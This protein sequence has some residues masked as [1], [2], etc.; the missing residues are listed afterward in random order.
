MLKMMNV[1]AMIQFLPFIVVV[2]LT[3]TLA[4]PFANVPLSFIDVYSTLSLADELPWD[5]TL[6]QAFNAGIEYRPL[7]TL[8]NKLA[9]D[10]IGLELRVYQAIVL[11]QFAGILSVL[12]WL[13]KPVGASRVLAATVALICVT[14]LHSSRILFNFNP[15]NGGSAVLLVILLI[16]VWTMEPTARRWDYLYFPTALVM[17]LTLEFGLLLV[18]VLGALRLV[19]APGLTTRGVIAAVLGVAVYAAIHLGLGA[20]LAAASHTHSGLGF[21]AATPERLDATFGGWLWLFWVYNVVATVFTV[22]FSEPR[23]GTYAFIASLMQDRPPTWMWLHVVSSFATTALILVVFPRRGLNTRDRAVTA[24]GIALIIGGSALGFLY[25]RDR[26]ALPVGI[27]YA[28]LL[29]VALSRLLAAASA[30][31]ARRTAVT[32]VVSLL[33]VLWLVRDAELYW[34]LR[35]LAWEHNREWS[36][37]FESIRDNR[38]VT[39]LMLVLQALA[40]ERTPPDPATSPRWSHRLLERK[41]GPARP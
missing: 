6:R 7:L 37:R 14:G 26:I 1:K 21:S 4:V 31:V 33:T 17:T 22:A 34:F 5:A 30:T 18:P 28:M 15:L 39:D 20:P 19:R 27:G 25:T 9:Y 23:E 2:A 32:A 35:D 13:F 8:A 24:V 41:F 16:A 36:V 38:P 40:L 3:A 29:Y 12:L 11:L 10:T